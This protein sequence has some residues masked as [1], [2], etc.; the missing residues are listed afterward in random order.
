LIDDARPGR[1][2]GQ[3]AGSVLVVGRDDEARALI[4]EVLDSLGFTVAAAADRAA[5]LDLMREGR[6]D[7]VVVD[8]LEQAE[9]VT[10]LRERVGDVR[11]T[12][13]PVAVVAPSGALSHLWEAGVREV[14]RQPFRTIELVRSVRR[15]VGQ[16][17]PGEW[18]R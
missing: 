3:R 6:V 5:T 7:A 18:G 1:G 13:I 4:V 17:T 14:I 9:L 2:G 8:W 12:G 16:A 10:F 11:L 15:R